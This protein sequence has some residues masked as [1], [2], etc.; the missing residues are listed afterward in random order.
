MEAIPPR[1]GGV[2]LQHIQVPLCR[3]H[4]RSPFLS[5]S[6]RWKPKKLAG[7]SVAPVLGERPTG[8]WPAISSPGEKTEPSNW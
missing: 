3:A 2:S 1:Q 6:A 8:F 7:R 4:Q 5:P